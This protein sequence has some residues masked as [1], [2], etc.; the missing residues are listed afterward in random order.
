MKTVFRP[1]HL[2]EEESEP[3]RTDQQVKAP[4]TYHKS[5]SLGVFRR[6]IQHYQVDE[7]LNTTNDILFDHGILFDKAA[8]VH[9]WIQDLEGINVRKDNGAKHSNSL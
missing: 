2:C 5:V 6:P 4:H 7:R 9:L 3:I 8:F 1:C